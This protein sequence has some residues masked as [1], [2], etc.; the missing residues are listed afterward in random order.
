MGGAEPMIGDG[1]E[2]LEVLGYR[3]CTLPIVW[4]FERL[5]VS[6]DIAIVYSRR[7]LS[8]FPAHFELTY[9]RTTSVGYKKN[10]VQRVGYLR[11]M[12]RQTAESSRD[13]QRLSMSRRRS[14]CIQSTSETPNTR[15]SSSTGS[16]FLSRYKGRLTVSTG[17][18]RPSCDISGRQC[19]APF[20]E[21][22]SLLPD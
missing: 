10:E 4:L 14:F 8:R 1:D 6:T 9:C 16:P 22:L 13:R 21:F 17:S 19:P 15:F 5:P 7:R 2:G 11:G 20:C 18:T 3:F 12:E